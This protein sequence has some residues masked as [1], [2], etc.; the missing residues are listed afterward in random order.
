M[1]YRLNKID[2]DLRQRINDATKEG[3]VHSK[4][5]IVINKD[6]K[7]QKGYSLKRYNRKKKLI[8]GAVKP[9]NIE[10]E[11]FKEGMKEK[12]L[13]KGTYIDIKK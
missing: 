10:V 8:V 2:T 4:K 7:K 9:E 3:K 6:T 13:P 12:D 11:A 1:E 5:E